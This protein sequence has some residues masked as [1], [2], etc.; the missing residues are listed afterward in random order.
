MRFKKYLTD[1]LRV[2]VV[3]KPYVSD[4]KMRKTDKKK[5][6]KKVKKVK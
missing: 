6:E 3:E 5:S 2:T 4:V 1:E